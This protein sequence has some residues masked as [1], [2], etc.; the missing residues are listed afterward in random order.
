M[1][2]SFILIFKVF[3]II[4]ELLITL[5]HYKSS[6]SKCANSTDSFVIHSY[7]TSHLVS[8]LDGT[9]CLHRVD[10][11]NGFVPLFNSISTFMDYLIPKPSLK[12]SSGTI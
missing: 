7:Q 8:P 6:S 5:S 10:E 9:W 4:V 1:S 3:F 12:D 2:I 11:P